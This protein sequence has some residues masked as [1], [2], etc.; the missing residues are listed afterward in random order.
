LI[1]EGDNMDEAEDGCG[2]AIGICEEIYLHF[3][4]RES[5]Q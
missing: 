1:D 4:V 5:T 3:V 2:S